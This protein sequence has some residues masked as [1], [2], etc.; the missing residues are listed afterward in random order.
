MKP[1]ILLCNWT[2]RENVPG[3]TETRYSYLK[4][5]FP[6][7]ELISYIDLF[8]DGE[9]CIV[10][11]D[12]AARKMDEYYMKRYEED[13]NI[14]II[15]DAEVGGILD[16]SHIPQITIFANPYKSLYEIFSFG[17]GCWVGLIELQKKAEKTI[18]VATSNFMKKDME[19]NGLVPDEIISNPVDTDFFR[20]LT[21]DDMGL[22]RATGVS[23]KKQLRDQY[24]IPRDR[25]VGI[26]VGDYTNQIKNIKAISY[27]R[28]NSNIFWIMVSKGKSKSK[29]HN[30]RSFS[31]VDKKTMRDLYNCA[32]FFIL[33]SPVEGFGMATLEAMACDV[34]CIISPVGY[35][36][37]FWDER[38]GLKIEWNDLLAHSM[39]VKKINPSRMIDDVK[40][41]PREVVI[42]R[43]LDLRTCKKK[44]DKLIKKVMEQ[45]K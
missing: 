5:I 27:L 9:L 25:K 4:Q 23:I 19:K 6:D 31:N 33:T 8:N 41:K 21:F 7:A 13:K 14:L 15:R 39:A 43:G 2:H 40:I 28:K 38:I 11:R 26:W 16:T 3:G 12:E 1:K 18:K 29:K 10:N 24:K 37:D 44:W 34:P 32:D 35:F 42:E 22:E 45:T 17:G 36:Y 20:P 30:I